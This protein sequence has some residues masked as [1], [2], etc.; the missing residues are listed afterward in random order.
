MLGEERR[1][2]IL[3]LLREQGRVHVKDLSRRFRTSEVTIRN[4]LKELH[5]RGLARRAHGGAVKPEEPIIESPLLE[6]VHAH[7]DEK[8]RIGA[9]AAAL[10]GD[11]E[12][13]IIDSGSTTHEIAKRIKHRQGLQVITNG[14]NVAMELVGAQG[15][16][17]ILLG[18]VLKKD[19]FSVVGH[20]PEVMLGELH[21]DRF[22]I[23]AAGVDADFGLSNS[24][25]EEARVNQ[26]MLKIARE[27]I[28][29][30]DSS[31]FGRRSLVRIVALAEINKV[32]T[33][34]GLDDDARREL[35]RRGVELIL[36]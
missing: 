7:A 35:E 18:G 33:D 8:R 25:L 24:D 21:A 1:T 28:L 36:A 32:I 4:D 17:V 3:H 12:T 19:S 26:A 5:L 23:G 30:A 31:K 15:I 20:F 27:K 6:R 11:G 34:A 16:Q 10:I 2:Q 14:V 13:V 29:V 22:F 9:A